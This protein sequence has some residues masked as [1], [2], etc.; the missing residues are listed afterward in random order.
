MSEESIDDTDAQNIRVINNVK[1]INFGY[2][3]SSINPRPADT[4]LTPHEIDFKT[5]IKFYGD[6]CCYDG[7]NAI[8]ESIQPMMHRFNTAQ[9]E[10]KRLPVA[11]VSVNS[12]MMKSIGMI[13]TLE[14]HLS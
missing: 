5:D 11:S 9:R 4:N 6:L 12:Y 14:M 13:M 2:D 7:Y 8:E 3:V 1:G 10:S